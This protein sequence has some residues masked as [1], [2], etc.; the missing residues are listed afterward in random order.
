MVLIAGLFFCS[1]CS[2]KRHV[3]EGS[4]IV[5]KNIINVDAS[6][7]YTRKVV[8]ASELSDYI[9]L[10]KNK[11]LFNMNVWEY[12]S[13]QT[14]FKKWLQKLS[15]NPP[16][17]YNSS[18]AETSVK[19][20]SSYLNNRGYF[21]SS[22]KYTVTQFRKHPKKVTVIYDV[23]LAKPYTIQ[24]IDYNIPDSGI[25]ELITPHFVEEKIKV[26]QQYDFY[27][28]DEVRNSITDVLRNSGY[29]F[30]NADYVFFEIDSSFR[31]H[32]LKIT[33][34]IRPNYLLHQEGEQTIEDDLYN[35]IFYF[36]EI[37][38]QPSSK[39]RRRNDTT[40]QEVI[41]SV[42]FIRPH[43]QKLDDSVSYT[44]LQ[45]GKPFMRNK[46]LMPSVFLE[47]GDLYRE[48]DIKRTRT[49]ITGLPIVGSCNIVLDTAASSLFSDTAGFVNAKI[50]LVKGTKQGYT[51]GLEATD[52]TGAFGTSV[53]L[54]YYNKNIFRGAEMLN[55]QFKLSAE[56]QSTL[57]DH[58]MAH[59]FWIFNTLEGGIQATITFPKFF[60][61]I[62]QYRFPKYFRPK[63]NIS[64]G[65]NF[66]MRPDYD[67]SIA[68]AS[69]GYFWKPDVRQSHKLTLLDMNV[70]KI[71]K[72]APFE[73]KIKSYNNKRLYEQYSDHFIMA[74][75]YTFT[76]STQE[77]GK[78]KDF[79]YVQTSLESG[80]NLL[81][82][83]NSIAK[84][85]KTVIDNTSYYSI[86][87]I[88][89]AE[90]LKGYIELRRYRYV[91]KYNHFAYRGFFGIG[92]P[93]GNALSLPFEK[94]F[95]GGGANDMRGWAINLV[96]PGGYLND[97]NYE[98]SG[99]IKLEANAEFRFG[100]VSF[101]KG[102]VFT[103]IGNV[104]LLRKED[105]FKDG[106]FSFSKFYKQFYWDAGFGLRLDFNF[107]LIRVDAAIGLYNPG[108]IYSTKWV[109]TKSHFKDV[110][111]SFGIGYPF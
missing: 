29:L 69:Y 103:D 6:D 12:N 55:L 28:L 80:G 109:I 14:K 63:T 99:D 100:I 43:Y 5:K 54:S 70:V 34:N 17:Y 108:S 10:P 2:V 87:G 73:E 57:G 86:F 9:S 92:V 35:R 74:L 27:R 50:S 84:S 37:T 38:V 23:K 13:R 97:N 82:A 76:F 22:V 15:D 94:S 60:A 33:L 4:K 58:S 7:V 64:V 11:S 39:T 32:V 48:Q 47:P 95:Y 18:K 1:S 31:S 49:A 52:N 88:R 46:A 98:R 81:Y 102:A 90:Y 66:Q 20:L 62:N 51:V 111:L 59:A 78:A 91:G 41:D 30:F 21:N 25:A 72:T 36:N 24:S 45:S 104:W 40:T 85:P 8:S 106:E 79:V 26:G 61:P 71:D 3:P 101:L 105:S 75:N 96:G 83:I 65:Y 93:Y 110:V 19:R 77:Y 67:R 56:S 89:Y 68:L 42:I 53:S 16:S 44:I 107:F